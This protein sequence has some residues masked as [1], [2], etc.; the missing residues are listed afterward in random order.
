MR[1]KK[2]MKNIMLISN[3]IWIWINYKCM[4]IKLI[5]VIK[6]RYSRQHGVRIKKKKELNLI[7]IWINSFTFIDSVTYAY[8]IYDYIY[9]SVN[10][11]NE[12]TAWNI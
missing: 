2:W 11:L 10:W 12:I 4:H 8:Y 7:R 6:N 1:E 9:N 3:R 5:I